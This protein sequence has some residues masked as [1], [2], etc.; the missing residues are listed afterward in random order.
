MFH[1]YLTHDDITSVHEKEAEQYRQNQKIF[2]TTYERAFTLQQNPH[3]EMSS[4]IKL[5]IQ[6]IVNYFTIRKCNPIDNDLAN[7][8]LFINNC[9]DAIEKENI[10]DLK[11]L[12][13]EENIKK[14]KGIFRSNRV[15]KLCKAVLLFP[16]EQKTAIKIAL[17]QTIPITLQD[18]ILSY[19]EPM[20]IHKSQKITP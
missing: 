3:L 18:I 1:D 16:E 19:N 5:F 2:W 8:A 15:Y 4:N 17:N 10:N 11:K 6:G 20:H 14:F 7:R 9:L 12:L 13:K